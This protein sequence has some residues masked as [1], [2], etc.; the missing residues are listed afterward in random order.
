MFGVLMSLLLLEEESESFGTGCP[1]DLR[2]TFFSSFNG[3]VGH[4]V[5]VEKLKCSAIQSKLLD[6]G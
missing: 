3:H 2:M 4:D 5:R 1:L 6:S